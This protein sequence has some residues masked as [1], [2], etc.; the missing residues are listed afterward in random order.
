MKCLK[1]ANF[2]ELSKL[3]IPYIT[4]QQKLKNPKNSF[5]WFLFSEKKTIYYNK[6]IT[7][8]ITLPKLLT[9][10]KKIFNFFITNSKYGNKTNLYVNSYQSKKQKL[11]I[12]NIIFMLPVKK[13]LLLFTQG[14]RTFNGTLFKD[15]IIVFVE[16]FKFWGSH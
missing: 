15:N 11:H 2:Q 3:Y 10:Q 4:I 12:P 8:F 9:F 6:Q 13:K 7:K 1:I 14:E 16:Y 5:L